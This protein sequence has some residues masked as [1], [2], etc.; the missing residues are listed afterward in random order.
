[1][2][3]W[4]SKLKY[5]AKSI[6]KLTAL[7]ML[8]A[9]GLGS[10]EDYCAVLDELFL[11]NPED[12]FLLELEDCT[13]DAAASLARLSPLMSSGEFDVDAFG[14]ELFS[15]LEK[16][17]DSGAVSMKEFGRRGYNLWCQF[18]REFDSDEPFFT[19][20]WADEFYYEGSG[21]QRG[22]YQNA[23]DYYKEKQR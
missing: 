6:E 16:F 23:F 22:Y 18:P 19:L 11:E 15:Q 9:F 13:R 1:M 5:K 10:K 8:W 2:A 7:C 12:D 17:C 3:D 14:R 20:C 4:N 21:W